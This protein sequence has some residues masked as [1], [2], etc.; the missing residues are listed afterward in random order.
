MFAAFDS[1]VDS[2]GEDTSPKRIASLGMDLH[3]HDW[4]LLL[5]CD[6]GMVPTCRFKQR[7][8]TTANC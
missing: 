2:L 6:E 8:G 4:P 5:L 7:A 3:D 1:F